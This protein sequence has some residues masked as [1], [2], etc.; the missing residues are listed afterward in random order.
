MQSISFIGAG[1]LGTT[2]AIAWHRAGMPVTMIASRNP[3]SARKAAAGLE[4]C[5]AVTPEQAVQADLV[6]LTVPDDDI[7]PLAAS[8]PWRKGQYVVHCSGAT[9]VSV[10]DAAAQAGAITGGYHPMQIF[11]D[12]QRTLALLPG[13][14]AG[15]EGPP[16]LEQILRRLA[17]KLGM[18]PM[19]LPP[20]SR[21]LYHGGSLF[22]GT[23]L[24]SMLNEAARAWSAFG[25]SEE[26]TLRALL[27]VARG[28]LETAAVK[29]VAASLAGPISRGDIKV[30]QRHL[31]AL[32][33][34]SEE[35]VSFYRQ[36][37]ARQLQLARRNGKLQQHQLDALQEAIGP[38]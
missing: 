33:Q 17:E 31:R 36:L 25:I 37:A 23:F 35:Q 26:Q 12:P 38:G 28:T 19:L 14:T 18:V 2:L 9:E 34:L 7:G 24:L 22:V 10:L 21:A 16:A 1:R 5:A 11:S 27:P 20:G 30:V 8:L 13:A 32:E 4:G 6:F 3:E 29:G 15:I